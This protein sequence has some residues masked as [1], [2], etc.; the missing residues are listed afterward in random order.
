M[1]ERETAE[2]LDDDIS[3]PLKYRHTH[4]E[5]IAKAAIR[6]WK[7]APKALPSIVVLPSARSS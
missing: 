4:A 2:A 6:D 3:D 7:I 1:L 5:T